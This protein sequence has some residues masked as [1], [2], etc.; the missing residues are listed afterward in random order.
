MNRMTQTKL[1]LDWNVEIYQNK[2]NFYIFKTLYMNE[3]LLLAILSNSFIHHW[4]ESL[5]LGY[6]VYP[7]GTLVL[8]TFPHNASGLSKTLFKV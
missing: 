5:M 4:K 7:E 1:K 3:K 8:F 6:L 2:N